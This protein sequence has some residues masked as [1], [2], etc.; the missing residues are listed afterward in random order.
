MPIDFLNKTCRKRSKTER[1]NIIIE[2]NIFEIVQVQ[3]FSLKWKCWIFGPLW[4]ME[5]LYFRSKKEKME[6]HHRILQIWISLGSKFQL[7][8]KNL[9]F[10]EQNCT[11]KESFRSKATKNEHH[12]WI[13]HIR[14]SLGTKLQLELK[15]LVFWVKF[16]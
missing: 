14:I 4:L 12:H 13:L 9:I 15:I 8:Q 6:N 3:N 7:Q 10:S 16:A 1:V 5:K 2:F 11:Q